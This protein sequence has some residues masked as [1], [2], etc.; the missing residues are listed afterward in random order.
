MKK[1]AESLAMWKSLEALQKDIY[2]ENS[3]VLL[4]TLKNLGVCYMG[5]G[6]TQDAKF[7]FNKSLKLIQNAMKETDSDN[8]KKK[9]QIEIASIYQN[10]YLT[11]IA[12][13]QIEQAC[14][15][16]D[17]A[18]AILITIFGPRSKRLASK[19]Y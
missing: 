6:N 15:F 9:D 4:F 12:D 8:Q 7:F 14:E 1:Y 5:I 17:K 19:Y 10:L 2:G 13:H 3:M 18:E 16:T 11:Y